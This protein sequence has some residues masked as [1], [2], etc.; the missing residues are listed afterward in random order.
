[1][2][3]RRWCQVSDGIDRI[4]RR[5]RHLADQ[6]PLL[7]QQPIEER[8]LADVR[9]ADDGDAHFVGEIARAAGMAG[10]D[11]ARPSASGRCPSAPALADAGSTFTISSS[12]SPTPVPC[13]AEISRTGSNPSSI[14]LDARL[15][16]LSSVLLTARTTGRPVCAEL[17][18]DRLVARHQPFPSIDEKHQQ[19]RAFDRALSLPDDQVVQRILAGAGQPAGIEQVEGRPRPTTPGAPARRASCRQRARRSRGGSR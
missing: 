15:A 16:R 8:R 11:V 10:L 3:N 12:R 18:R 2:R 1:M 6:H 9:A 17:A 13:S 4:A 14:E 7:L 5:S 19:I